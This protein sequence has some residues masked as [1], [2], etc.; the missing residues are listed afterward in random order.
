MSPEQKS[1]TQFKRLTTHITYDDCNHMEEFFKS[2]KIPF[3]HHDKYEADV[4]CKWLVEYGFAD[5]SLSN[6]TDLLAYGC[7]HILLDFDF[8][9]NSVT[10]IDYLEMLKIIE[11]SQSQFLD[12]CISCG[13]DYNSR[14]TT[15]K[16]VYQLLKLSSDDLHKPLY[17]NLVDIINDITNIIDTANERLGESI[18]FLCPPKSLDY[19]KVCSIF[20][21]I[22]ERKD[23][24]SFL[25]LGRIYIKKKYDGSS[26]DDI[27]SV[28]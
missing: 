17:D 28:Y 4:V 15:T 7:K 23:M 27:E 12:L 11:L 9:S 13:S 26:I 16:I 24:I 5:Y 20:N 21:T 25:E 2:N 8:A 6:D 1:E 18:E 14:F 22:L 3:I 19:D 10:Y